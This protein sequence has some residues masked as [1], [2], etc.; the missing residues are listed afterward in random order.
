MIEIFW[1]G[2]VPELFEWLIGASAKADGGAFEETEGRI[3]VDG[4]HVGQIGGLTTK[5]I[6]F[7][8]S[9]ICA[10]L[11]ITGFIIWWGKRKKSRSKK[12]KAVVHRRVHK[13][14]LA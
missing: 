6:A 13:Q 1:E 8:A 5:I 2:R 4:L 11:P 9:L 7:L 14:H 12:V 3:E 10:S